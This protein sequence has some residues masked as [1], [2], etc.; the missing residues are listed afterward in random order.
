MIAS[1]HAHR[2]LHLPPPPIL[3]RMPRRPDLQALLDAFTPTDAPEAKHHARMR[4]LLTSPDCFSRSHFVPGHFTASSFVL[5]P[6]RG[7]LL[8]IMHAK[9]HRWLQ[10]GGHVDPEDTNILAAA[11]REV[12][13][14]VGIAQLAGPLSPGERVAESARPGEGAPEVRHAQH[15]VEI[16][17][18]D[19]HPIPAM[20]GEPG[21]EHFDVRFLFTAPDTDFTAGSD[22]KDAR[23]VPLHEVTA[24]MTDASVMRAI[25]KLRS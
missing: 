21:H 11:R 22:A 13:E 18:L 7:S 1:R 17:D 10:P 12:L 14:E 5:S 16:F 24:E 2:T 15:V 8:L 19:I 3:T 20:K 25:A 4:E 6:D 9:L 23:W